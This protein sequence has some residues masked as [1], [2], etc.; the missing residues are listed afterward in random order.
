MEVA[1]YIYTAW[2]LVVMMMYGIDKLF[3]IR[4]K[5]RISEAT[6]VMSAFFLGGLGAILAMVIFNHKT[7]KKKFRF[8]VPFALILN[9]LFILFIM[10]KYLL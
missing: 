8:S 5:R 1:F 9:I 4:R 7:S 3:A 2:N 10:Q 6:L